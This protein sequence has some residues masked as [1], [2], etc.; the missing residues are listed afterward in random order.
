MKLSPARKAAYEILLKIEAEHAYSSALLASYETKLNPAD[1]GLCHEIVLG[2][3]RRQLLLDRYIEIFTKHRKL[4]IEVIVILRTGLFQLYNLDRVPA[5]AVV[6]ESVGLTQFARKSSA[7][8]LVN[9]VLRAA[10][11]GRPETAFDSELERIA[12]ETSHPQWLLSKWQK[13]NDADEVENQARSNNE[14][15]PITFRKTIKGKAIEFPNNIAESSSVPG[16][17]IAKSFSSEL[18]GLSDQGEIY[19]QE[20]ASQM[21]AA[22]VDIRPGDRFL[23]VCASPGGKTTAIAF[24][25]QCAAPLT[26]DIL[27][28]AGDVNW[29]RVQLLK[30]TCTKQSA[31]TVQ[32]VQYDA[33]K[34]LPFI[35]DIFDHVLVDAPCTGTGTIRHNPEIRY[36]V[37]PDDFQRMHGIQCA[38]LG[39]ASKLVKPGGRLTYSTCSLEREENEDVCSSFLSISPNWSLTSTNIPDKFRTKDGYART[40]P[41]RDGLDA[42]FIATFRRS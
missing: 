17:F 35:D 36:F 37:Q 41:H 28:V 26:N 22:A 16:C 39:N 27:I 30:S 11:K 4:D 18:A 9:A 38:I 6:N 10:I 42:F 33:A 25:G 7:R 29:R 34:S 13:D 19:F 5:Y 12:I 20:E 15:P 1:R 24:R 14:P 2:V 3:L 21:V 23:D 31:E 40:L 32:I 8:G